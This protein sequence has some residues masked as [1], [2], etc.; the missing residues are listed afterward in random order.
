MTN[1]MQFTVTGSKAL[2]SENEITVHDLTTLSRRNLAN[3]QQRRIIHAT[4]YRCIMMPWHDEIGEMTAIIE[5]WGIFA[6]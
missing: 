3:I 5:L 2:P 6:N 4:K 1:R